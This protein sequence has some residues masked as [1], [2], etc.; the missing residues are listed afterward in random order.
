MKK[1]VCWALV[2][3]M[4]VSSVNT[5][6]VFASTE[7][8]G[9]EAFLSSVNKIEEKAK[10]PIEEENTKIEEHQKVLKIM[11]LN[12]EKCNTDDL[13]DNYAGSYLNDEGKMVVV[14]DKDESGNK[15]LE[16]KIGKI[17]SDI[18]V[19]KANHNCKELEAAKERY[20]IKM[21]KLLEKN[22][23][24]EDEKSI[25]D[26]IVGCGISLE[27]N[28]VT[29]YMKNVDK[30][31]ITLFKKYVM[32]NDIIEFIQNTDENEDSATK[33]KLGR[34]IYKYDHT[35]G[36][37]IWSIVCSIGL[38]AY[39]IDSNGKKR[40]GFVTCGHGLKKGDSI[41]IDELC[42]TKIGTVIKRKNSG[43]VDASFVEVT[44]SNYTPSRVVYY[45]NSTGSTS[46]GKTISTGYFYAWY[47]GFT[48]YKAGEKTYLTSGKLTSY[49]YSTTIDD[50][51]FKDLYRAKI[52]MRKGDSGGIFYT[53][54]DGNYYALG[55]AKCFNNS[56]AAFVKWNNIDD[57]FGIYFY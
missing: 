7:N 42:K 32:D 46:G 5:N 18:E 26:N 40:Y 15:K 12:D 50:V 29:V 54:D 36:N 3:G 22:K 30:N 19:K 43:K 1:T 2:L 53:K 37:V 8:V 39:T 24:T 23:L 6:I 45:S 20:D 56:Y 28:R 55:I 48:V 14:L 52:K 16:S 35:S 44:N 11:G 31:N 51:E 9:K 47:T 49:N 21:G 38:K 10:K 25:C 13:R 34:A 57:A 33:L 17:D 41:Y 4:L 27:N